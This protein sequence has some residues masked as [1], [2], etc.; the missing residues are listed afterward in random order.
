MCPSSMD[1]LFKESYGEPQ[2][3]YNYKGVQIP[4]LEIMDDVLTV[5]NSENT[6]FVR[7]GYN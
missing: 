5:T 2:H 7:E 3:L 1:G 6:K 4:P